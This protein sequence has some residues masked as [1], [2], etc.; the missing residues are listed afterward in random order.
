MFEFIAENEI[1]ETVQEKTQTDGSRENKWYVY[2]HTNKTNNKKYF[3]ITSQKPENRWNYGRGYRGQTVFWNAI[4][5]YGWNGF[6]HDIL[7][8]NLTEYEADKKEIELIALYKTNCFRSYNPSYGYNC[9]DGGAGCHTATQETKEKM[10][11]AAK[12]RFSNPENIPWKG[13]PRPED[14]KRRISTSSIGKKKSEEARKKMS[15][16]KEELYKN[17]K[18][19]QI[20][21]N[22]YRKKKR[23]IKRISHWYANRD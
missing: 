16:A 6:E 18:I 13:R 3:G 9:N 22:I 4:Q 20:T 10:S 1:I 12:I 15:K 17:Q 19:I 5:K 14:T 11:N 7:F 21:V 2:C 8:E 23:K